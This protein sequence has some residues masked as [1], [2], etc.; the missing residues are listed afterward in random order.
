MMIAL[1]FTSFVAGL[2]LDNGSIGRVIRRHRALPVLGLCLLMLA[3]STACTAAWLSAV[4][5]MIPSIETLTS[6]IIAFIVGL[7]GKTVSAATAAFVQKVG[8]DIQAE[9]LNAQT[10]IAAYKSS[11][12]TTSLGKI[13][14]VFS[15]IVASL[16]SILSNANVTDVS[17][18]SK[19]Q[20]LVGLAV[21]AIQA[22]LGMIP[23]VINATEKYAQKKIDAADVR[24]ADGAA[25]SLISN[26]HQELTE[27]Y[28]LIRDTPSGSAEVDAVLATLPATI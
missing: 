4:S 10:L 17:T 3:V 21:A 2:L 18:V 1:I 28:K 22:V 13:S 12:S 24:H 27:G 5:A 16:G 23:L 20:Q 6:A 14:E 26:R 11:P 8:N 9:I 7:E 15:A 25:A 19:I